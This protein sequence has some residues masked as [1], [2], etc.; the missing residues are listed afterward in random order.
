MTTVV[1]RS[2]CA[3]LANALHCHASLYDGHE[4]ELVSPAPRLN[5]FQFPS[6]FQKRMI[7]MR[8]EDAGRGTKWKA[9]GIC[10]NRARHTL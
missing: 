8:M 2:L 3:K 6:E 10:G 4:C 9:P 7:A 1:L 5:P